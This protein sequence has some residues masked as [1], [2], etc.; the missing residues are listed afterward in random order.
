[1]RL[2]FYASLIHSRDPA[3]PGFKGADPPSQD[4]KSNIG[5]LFSALHQCEGHPHSGILLITFW[6]SIWSSTL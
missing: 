6:Q 5:K 4:E 2:D 1:M 3:Q